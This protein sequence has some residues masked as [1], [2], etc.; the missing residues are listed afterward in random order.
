MYIEVSR[1]ELF[2]D[3]KKACAVVGGPTFGL[4]IP[5]GYS[6]QTMYN[7]EPAGVVLLNI[8]V[9]QKKRSSQGR[10]EIKTGQVPLEGGGPIL[11][12]LSAPGGVTAELETLQARYASRSH[13]LVYLPRKSAFA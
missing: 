4:N 6:S 9:S 8:P 2:L 3:L 7:S 10:L 13:D 11:T 1:D 5:G 12:G